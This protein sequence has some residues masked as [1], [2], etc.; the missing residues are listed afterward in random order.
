MPPQATPT[1]I[2]I[3]NF[4]GVH[5]GHA[6]LVRRA[7]ACV[8]DSGRVVALAFDPS[9][10]TLLRPEATPGRLSNFAQR[11]RW[12]KEAGADE[13]ERLTPTRELL[14]LS[15]E[16]FV[17]AKV[18]RYEPAFIV[19]GPDFHFG[20]G[21]AGN[22]RTLAALGAGLGFRCEVVE[23]IEVSL[24][25]HLITRASSTILRWLVSHGRVRD[26]AR[27]LG[28]PYEIEGTVRQGDRRG[29]TI[30]VPT[31]N[32][33]SDHLLPADGVYAAIA[34]LADGR[35]F[36]AAANV[37]SRPTFAG[38]SRR[39]EAHLLIPHADSTGAW[40]T[41][42]GLPEYGWPIR[43]ELISWVREDL[44]F[45]GVGPLVEQMARDIGVCRERLGVAHSQ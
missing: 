7:R 44:R 2:T 32:I 14:D 17:R 45:E 30:G 15:A 26:A 8:G 34:T 36:G 11:E 1:A 22:V 6:A 35:E 31:A 27:V 43:L 5:V 37:G 10:M 29:R 21:R 42:S 3:G 18:D 39:L 9:P 13:V 25:D 38:T 24:D 28:R 12:L 20:K 4:D 23:P 40:S 41:I 16:A 33:E 19:E